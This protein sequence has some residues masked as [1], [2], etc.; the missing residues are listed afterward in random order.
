MRRARLYLWCSICPVHLTQSITTSWWIDSNTQS[1]LQTQNFHGSI[2]TS[3]NVTRESPWTTQHQLIV[4][5]NVACH[6]GQY[7]DQLY[8][9]YTR[10]PLVTSLHDMAC[11]TI[12]MLT[13]HKYIWQWNITSPSQKK[14]QRSTNVWL[15]WLT[16]KER[17]NLSWTLRSQRQSSS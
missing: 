3:P 11:N 8:T 7:L 6:K 9:A 13:S 16:G 17:T 1:A 4:S 10:D 14:L 15:R 12:V 2:R 5:W